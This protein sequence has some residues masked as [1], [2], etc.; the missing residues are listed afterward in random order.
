MNYFVKARSNMLGGMET[1][2][3]PYQIQVQNTSGRKSVD[4][5]RKVFINPVLFKRNVPHVLRE[6]KRRDQKLLQGY[7][8]IYGL[9]NFDD[10]IGLDRADQEINSSFNFIENY[11][12]LFNN[13][14]CVDENGQ[15]S[16]LSNNK[17]FIL[18]EVN[19]EERRDLLKILPDFRKYLKVNPCSL[20]S[21]VYG[22]FTFEVPRMLG[23]K[24]EITM[25]LMRNI[26]QCDVTHLDRQYKL[27]KTSVKKGTF[28]ERIG[29]KI[30]T[31]YLDSLLGEKLPFD[32]NL[33]S[34][35]ME[36][37]SQD[38]NFLYSLNIVNYSLR[39]DV[40]NRKPIKN[41]QPVSSSI[42]LE[43]DEWEEASQCS[44]NALPE[45]ISPSQLYISEGQRQGR[46]D[47]FYGKCNENNLISLVEIV[48][49]WKSGLTK[50]NEKSIWKK[51]FCLGTNRNK[52]S[53]INLPKEYG[54]KLLGTIEPIL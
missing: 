11:A 9:K 41:E 7:F 22:M 19:L 52:E 42:I 39:V 10:I 5:R 25:I 31:K 6:I 53:K 38:I 23:S 14:Y 1:H 47:S 28:T 21:R 46:Q 49:F 16:I 40:I 32:R 50:K 15:V 24:Q 8:T 20:L 44:L 3:S 36:R 27:D 12:N 29:Q 34:S 35:I 18:K 17:K 54:Q 30:Y 48:D 2:S 37:L 45:E 13:G 43:A 4:L 51:V 26:S 33:K